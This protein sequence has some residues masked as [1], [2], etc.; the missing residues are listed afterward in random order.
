MKRTTVFLSILTAVL[1]SACMDPLLEKPESPETRNAGKGLARIRLAGTP[2]S[3]TILPVLEGLSYSLAFSSGEETKN[4][5]SVAGNS[6]ELELASGTWALAVLGYAPSSQDIPVLAGDASF[7]VTA[8]QT[9]D[10]RVE[11][12]PAADF[13]ADGQGT[14]RYQVSFPPGLVRAELELVPLA[15]ADASQ[16]RTIDLL[17]DPEAVE[18]TE[19]LVLHAGYYRLVLALQMEDGKVGGK[20]EAVHI[21]QGIA[22]FAASFEAED[23]VP[24][25]IFTRLADM[26][27]W[28]ET[29]PR[30]TPEEPYQVSLRGIDLGPLWAAENSPNTLIESLG[31]RYVD[32]DLSGCIGTAIGN[33]SSDFPAQAHKDHLVGLTLPD[34]IK[35]IGTWFLHNYPNLKSVALPVGL[36]SLGNYSLYYSAATMPEWLIGAS[37]ETID[38]SRT[39]LA[40]LGSGV[41]AGNPNLREVKLP[42]TLTGV[43]SNVFSGCANLE[44]IVQEAPLTAITMGAIQNCPKLKSIRISADAT[45]G[46]AGVFEGCYSLSFEVEGAGPWSAGGAGNEMLLA[47]N[48]TTLAYWPS[49]AGA[50]AIPG[51]IKKIRSHAFAGN[52]RLASVDLGTELEEIGGDAFQESSLA[53][54]TLGGAIQTVG[55]YAFSDCKSLATVTVTAQN[56][57][58]IPESAF[59]GCDKLKTAD[60]SSSKVQTIG[61]RAFMDCTKL[62]SVSLPD[63]LTEVAAEIRSSVASPDN[64]S[65]FVNTPALA[66]FTVAPGGSYSTEFNGK[67]LIKTEGSV[68]TLVSYPTVKGALTIPEGITKIS[69]TAFRGNEYM[70]ALGNENITSVTFPSTLAELEASDRVGVFSQCKN[71]I[72]VDMSA[73]TGLTEIGRNAFAYCRKLANIAFPPNLTSIGNSAFTYCD[74]SAITNPLPS[75]ILTEIE[76]PGTLVVIGYG[77]FEGCDDLTTLTLRAETPPTL[78]QYALSRSQIYL[79]HI[80]VPAATVEVYK[81]N[82]D[83]SAYAALIS[84]IPTP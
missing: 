7:V 6:A 42:A 74:G 54:L 2:E 62:V 30:N 82:G 78:G 43:G 23:F 66:S 17:E 52:I 77:A 39:A 32:L 33:Q 57:T 67:A 80:Y 8:G 36:E 24:G 50:V 83:W 58:A 64:L 40:S 22:S 20:T 35:T 70:A 29:R 14:L 60:L 55:S 49:A 10:V 44:T 81:A 75:E 61:R 9:A 73:A 25:G 51:G 28:L 56:L 48:G 26:K 1:L 68:V 63:T 4:L 3:R 34:T 37:F 11:L 16:G 45:F 47:D 46:T 79:Q 38:L 5:P 84:A 21:Y 69:V 71:L 53:S 59:K 31:G 76:L 41:L 15:L 13:L 72:S 18:K 27:A 12:Y 65:A 19:D